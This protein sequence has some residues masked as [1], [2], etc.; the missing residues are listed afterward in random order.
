[1]L[2]RRDI[3]VH[4]QKYFMLRAAM[5]TWLVKRLS[6]ILFRLRLLIDKN[7]FG[8]KLTMMNSHLFI[9]FTCLV[10]IALLCTFVFYW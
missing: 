2:Q 9:P 10:F 3:D 1:M 4:C 8:K 7:S 6:D 5:L